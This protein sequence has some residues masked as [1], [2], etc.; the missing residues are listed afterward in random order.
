MFTQRKKIKDAVLI[1]LNQDIQKEIVPMKKH[2][3][4]VIKY[5]KSK[6]K[7]N[8]NLIQSILTK[9]KFIIKDT[10]KKIN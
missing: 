2:Q 7:I 8:I 10:M 5:Y 9:E 3:K 1:A 4:N 6:D